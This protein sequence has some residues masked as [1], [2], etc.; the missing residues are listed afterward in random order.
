DEFKSG[1]YEVVCT[2]DDPSIPR[3]FRCTLPVHKSNRVTINAE[4]ISLMMCQRCATFLGLGPRCCFDGCKSLPLP[5]TDRSIICEVS[6]CNNTKSEYFCS[7]HIRKCP[8]KCR[9]NM[10][11]TCYEKHFCSCGATNCSMARDEKGHRTSENVPM[12][13][14]DEC[15]FYK[16][17]TTPLMKYDEDV[18]KCAPK[19]VNVCCDC[20]HLPHIQELRKNPPVHRKEHYFCACGD[21]V[22]IESITKHHLSHGYGS[23]PFCESCGTRDIH[24]LHT[25]MA[26]ARCFECPSRMAQLCC[27][28]YVATQVI[29]EL[30]GSDE[31]P[32]EQVR[33][34][35]A[36]IQGLALIVKDLIHIHVHPDDKKL[37]LLKCD[38]IPS[39]SHSREA[40]L[41]F[42]IFSPGLDKCKISGCEKS[43]CRTHRSEVQFAVVCKSD[44]SVLDPLGYCLESLRLEFDRKQAEHRRAEKEYRRAYAH[45]DFY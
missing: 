3:C 36:G 17:K 11:L 12:S 38:F 43:V 29:P 24:K 35:L 30:S 34:L 45:G 23:L 9:W 22:C 44:H 7:K 14:C 39:Y 41:P 31:N 32:I 37:G 8:N 15:H 2:V 28:C 40:K 33:R 20:E 18:K 19:T 27:Q 16:H 4:F 10:C 25:A 42:P 6:N 13:R 26:K 21:R 1:T 5:I